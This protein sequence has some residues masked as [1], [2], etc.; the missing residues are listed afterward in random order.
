MQIAIRR[1]HAPL[2]GTPPA[3]RTMVRFAASLLVV[4]AAFAG[5]AWYAGVTPFSAGTIAPYSQQA[6]LRAIPFDAPLP[7]NLTLVEA[8][9]GRP[10]PYHVVWTS[11]APPNA[12]GQQ[13][14]D[15]L[16]G[17][18]KWQLAENTPLA[19]AFTTHLARETADGQMTHFATLSVT[20]RGTGSLVTLDFTP[21]PTTLAP[22]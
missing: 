3:P 21:I 2:L 5:A 13:V 7:Y 9:R 22:K 6:V 17:S 15:H 19:G 10:L 20:A 11:E 1:A 4:F 12:V 18:P 16:A 14:L 8:V